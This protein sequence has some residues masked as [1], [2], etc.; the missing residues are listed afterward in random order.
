MIDNF[1]M[2][3]DPQLEKAQLR[4]KLLQKRKALS[5][6]EWQEKSHRLCCHL[7]SSDLYQQSLTILSYISFRQEPDL[8]VLFTDKNHQW[9]LP[10]CVNKQLVWHRYGTGDTLQP[11]KYGI[12]E[13]L[14]DAPILEP[15]EVDLILVPSVGCDR[16]G[17]RLGYGG[18]FYD[19]LLSLPQWQSKPTL[20][21]LFNFGDLLDL[22]IA[23]WD[24]PLQGV[25]TEVG[26][27]QIP[28][29]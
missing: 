7:Q 8:S 29:E 16:Q 12:L 28:S 9:G 14:P 1:Q 18:G 27:R 2:S 24:K 15:E 6:E 4:L 13:P 20:G 19:R 3:L 23:S 5:P 21:I 10:R 17:Y 26:L 22:P 25:C 11:G